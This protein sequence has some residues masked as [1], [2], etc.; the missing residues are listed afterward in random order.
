MYPT[1][2]RTATTKIIQHAM[3]IELRLRDSDLQCII[4]LQQV[5]VRKAPSCY[6]SCFPKGLHSHSP[7]GNHCDGSVYNFLPPK[8]EEQVFQK[9][10]SPTKEHLVPSM[11]CVEPRVSESM[12]INRTINRWL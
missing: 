11:L 6:L 3:L 10:A 7:S 5:T 1:M 2:H 8:G 9:S 12:A 4:L